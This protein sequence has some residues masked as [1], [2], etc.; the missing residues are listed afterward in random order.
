M[1]NSNQRNGT[2]L[3]E[4]WFHFSECIAWLAAFM[5]QSIAIVTLN[6]VTII[7]FMKNRSL[8]KRSMYVVINLAVADMLVGGLSEVMNFFFMGWNCNFWQYNATPYGIWDSIIFSMEMMFPVASLTNITAISLE[9]LHATFFPFKHRV[10]K[11]WIFGVICA[12]IWVIAVLSS[13]IYYPTG[14]T[15]V[16]YFYQYIW[17]LFNLFCLFVICVSYASIA[18]KVCRGV[19]PRHHGAASREKKLTRTMSIMTIV[20]LLMYLPLGIFVSVISLTG[21]GSLSVLN[22]KRLNYALTI[23]CYTSS[24]VNPILYTFRMPDFKRALVS[25]LLCRSQQRQAVFPL[26]VM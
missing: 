6:V 13:G 7:V 24:L 23:L 11:K 1:N 12:A 19:H 26:R 21:Y 10:I 5:V 2:E 17:S 25:L 8:C 22:F 20:S 18:M 14:G 16:R 3:K 4:M 15:I 9:R